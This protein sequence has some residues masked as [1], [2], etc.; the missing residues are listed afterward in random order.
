MAIETVNGR[1]DGRTLGGALRGGL[2]RELGPFDGP[3]LPRS[4][5]N[6]RGSPNLKTFTGNEREGH[7]WARPR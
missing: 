7:V 6:W 4:G 2:G 3:S 5:Q 1:P